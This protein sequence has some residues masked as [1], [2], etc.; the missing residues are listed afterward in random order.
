MGEATQ[1]GGARAEAVN[2]TDRFLAF[3]R[4]YRSGGD[5]KY[6]RLARSAKRRIDVDVGDLIEA[7]GELAA[8]LLDRPREALEA[9]RGAVAELLRVENPQLLESGFSVG[10]AG[11]P[12]PLGVRELGAEHVGKLVAVRGV[13]AKIT[14]KRQRLVRGAWRCAECGE[15]AE[16]EEPPARCPSCGKR[17]FE[18][19][20]ERSAYAD[21]QLAAL[22]EPPEELEP[23][24][25][26]AQVHAL[27]EGGL[28]GS[29]KPGD[30]AIFT[31][32]AVP[33]EELRARRLL[34]GNRAAFRIVLEAVGVEV[35][36]R[37]PADELTPEDEEAILEFAKRP[38]AREQIIASIAPSIY[39]HEDVKKAIALLLFGG[40]PKVHPDG[41]RV[42]GDIHIL[43]VGD[44]GTAK[45]QLLR[46]VASVAPRGVYASGKGSTA[47][48][49]TAAVVKDPETGEF[50]LE[51][52]AMVLADGGVCCI[53][54]F[55]K[56]DARDRSA[57]HEAMEQQ[58]VSIAKAGIVATLNARASVLAAANPLFG[59][60]LPDKPVADNIGLPPTILSRFDLIFILTDAP[61]A[62][63]DRQL[64]LHVLH[65][66]GGAEPA[67]PLPRGFLR[68]YVAY[69]RRRCAPRLSEAAAKV[70]ADFYS[71]M[72]RRAQANGSPI[73][74]T[75]RQLEALVRM[76]EAHARMAL[77]G[78]VTEE[79][80]KAAIDLMVKFLR[81]AGVDVETG[82]IDVDAVMTGQPKSQ[83]ERMAALV[84]LLRRAVEEA[85]GGPVRRDDFVALAAERGFDE[86]FV[87]KVLAHLYDAGEII[88]PK[89]GYIVLL[90]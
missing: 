86:A 3:L 61:D 44:P 82:Q 2:L 40:V 41:V 66:H 53:D 87:R 20:A 4:T 73:P 62:E 37:D 63:R 18:L 31:G 57:I 23:G 79:D 50:A 64:A 13:V 54:E 70:I 8:W 39:G 16:G 51:A 42:R 84:A 34:A 60:Y 7:D 75:P 71:E 67:P 26:P 52:G 30:R 80:A 58:T 24:Q 77:S 29:V 76:A 48:G 12:R 47:A 59:R 81:G 43:L 38:D 6:R 27:L 17:R 1:Q 56:M 21:W 15:E 68:K 32:V 35:A 19:L 55:D 90:K 11:H 28:V 49:L 46:Y 89:P 22:Q 74:I 33:A 83:R 65:L 36:N 14:P 72:R 78:T 45:S 69:A 88:E 10:V 25:L 9:L 5:Y 85:G